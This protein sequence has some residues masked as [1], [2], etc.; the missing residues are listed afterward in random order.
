MVIE[1][2][3]LESVQIWMRNGGDN[4]TAITG[5]RKL[6]WEHY[7]Y[8]ALLFLNIVHENYVYTY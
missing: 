8:A 1:A 6:C 5:V 7:F 3:Y 4:N 2:D